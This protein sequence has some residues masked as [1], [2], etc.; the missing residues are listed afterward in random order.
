MGGVLIALIGVWVTHTAEYARI[1]GPEVVWRALPGS[2]HLYMLP[3]AGVLG[4]VAAQGGARLWRAWTAMG[5]RLERTRAG[6]EAAW[7]GR[8]PPH[9]LP[10][11]HSLPP[12][13]C[14]LVAL[15]LPL[16]AV[17]I[18]LY[19]LQEN[20]EA[21]WAG[22]PMPGL[23]P[24]TGLHWAAPLVHLA[25]ALL[26]ALG[27]SALL[28]LFRKRAHVIVACERLLRALM[29]AGAACIAPACP[30]RRWTPSPVDLFGTQILGRPP[31]ALRVT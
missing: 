4:L 5:W 25:V 20:A 17:Q 1:L 18:A 23:G 15:W 14:R 2:V 26:L 13:G 30:A 6:I 24:V 8:Q 10:A 27:A 21:R 22:I 29:V 28:G 9:P 7:R 3:L 11:A 31:P 12:F 16:A 19:L